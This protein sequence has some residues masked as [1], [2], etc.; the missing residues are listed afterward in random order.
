MPSLQ[1]EAPNMRRL[2]SADSHWAPPLT[3]ADEL[4]A[5][6]RAE[7]PH[8]E[9]RSDGLYYVQPRQGITDEFFVG[10]RKIS[11]EDADR[12]AVGAS[13]GAN[14]SPYPKGRLAEMAKE[15]VLGEVLIG[16]GG[17][18]LSVPDKVEMAWCTL[19]ND[20]LAENYRDHMHQFA[21][22]IHLPFACGMKAAVAELE[23]AVKLGLRPVL[24]PDYFPGK[25]YYLPEWEP[26]WEA[27]AA[28]KI[29]VTVH[30]S[31]NR[32]HEVRQARGV[33]RWRGAADTGLMA[34]SVGQV[35]TVCWFVFGGILER[36]PDLKIVMTEGSAGW[37]P[38]LT[39]Y[40]DYSHLGRFSQISMMM[41]GDKF[42]KLKEK[43]SE[44][45]K[46]QVSCTFMWD[47]AAIAARDITGLDC[48][49]WAND[50]PH[51]EGIFPTSQDH[52]ARQFAGVPEVEIDQMVRGNA[53]KIFG[54]TG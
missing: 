33:E 13:P 52:V 7:V 53:A 8:L 6:Y 49:I 48:L 27:A 43:P 35:E 42:A 26:L 44:Y 20:W 34:M 10:E 31:P 47:P 38:W 3:L 5:A 28:L 37:L 15:N 4:P 39:E 36:H 25:P 29:P 2:I 19:L 1:A 30:I 45:I 51:F 50:Y 21:P 18:G 16:P 23:R 14:P 41:T 46:R 24:L 17:F 22:G 54:L 12:V 11:S 40:A 32:G 9:E